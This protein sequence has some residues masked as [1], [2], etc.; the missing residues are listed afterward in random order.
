MKLNMNIITKV[1]LVI[2]IIL[3]LMANLTAKDEQSKLRMLNIS[4]LL[5]IAATLRMLAFPRKSRNGYM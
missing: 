1:F 4:V 3:C 2:G 5:L